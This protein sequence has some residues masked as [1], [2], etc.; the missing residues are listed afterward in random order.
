[1]AIYLS[2][3][4]HGK[5]SAPLH[6]WALNTTSSVAAAAQSSLREFKEHRAPSLLPSLDYRFLP[7]NPSCFH[8]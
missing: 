7:C 1:M 5:V 4:G 2:Q 6:N 8:S 3:A